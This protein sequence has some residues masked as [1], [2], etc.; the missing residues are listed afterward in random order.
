MSMGRAPELKETTC[1]VPVDVVKTYN[2]LRRPAESNG[3]VLV[4]L[5]RKVEY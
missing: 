5:K 3:L 2:S 1:N 4:K